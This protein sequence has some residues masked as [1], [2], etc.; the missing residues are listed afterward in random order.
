MP[1]GHSIRRDANELGRLFLGAVIRAESPQG[2]FTA[3]AGRL[4]GA[5]IDAVDA[6]GKHLFIGFAGEAAPETDRWLHVHRGLY[7]RWTITRHTPGNSAPI[8]GAVRLRLTSADVTADL[9]GPTCCEL[10]NAC[11]KNAVHA[12]LGADPLRPKGD[13]FANPELAW[14]KVRRSRTPIGA[15]VMRQD[16]IAGVGNV[17][18]AEALFRAGLDPYLPGRELTEDQWHALWADLVVLLRAGVR[19]GRIITTRPEDRDRP[20]GRARTIDAHYV[21]RRAGLPCRVC[22][23]LVVAE[24]FFARTLYGCPTCQSTLDYGSL[25]LE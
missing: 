10:L 8:R 22:G 6:H 2:R 24:T 14:V 19:S 3:G 23:T 12:R 5:V 11:D 18:R 15:L 25:S 21:Y 9:R 16:V 13:R 1:E 7:G 4:D 20:A 17:Y